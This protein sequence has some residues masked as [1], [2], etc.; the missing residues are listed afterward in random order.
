MQTKANNMATVAKTRG[1]KKKK[2][3][4]S[5]ENRNKILRAYI[6]LYNAFLLKNLM[7]GQTLGAAAYGALRLL[8]AKIPT[9]DKN[10]PTTKLLKRIH[11]YHTGVVSKRIMTNPCRDAVPNIRPD[12]RAKLA[13]FISK[14]FN[15]AN[16]VLNAM[17]ARYKPKQKMVVQPKIVSAKQKNTAKPAQNRQKL[18]LVIRMKQMQNMRQHVA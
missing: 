2:S 4:I 14:K 3:V 15:E 18:L 16:M 17:T 1:K 5:K 8:T 13:V 9:M 10:N 6:A 7:S 11:K 12:E